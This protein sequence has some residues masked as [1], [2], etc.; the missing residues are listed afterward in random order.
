MSPCTFG[1]LLLNMVFIYFL[2]P[3]LLGSASSSSEGNGGAGSTK[4]FVPCKVCGDKASGYHYGVTSCEG[5]KVRKQNNICVFF[6][7]ISLHLHFFRLVLTLSLQMSGIPASLKR[8][9]SKRRLTTSLFFLR[10]KNNSGS[11]LSQRASSGGVFRNRSSTGACAMASA[12]SSGSTA[13]AASTAASRNASPS[14]CRAIVSITH[15]FCT[16]YST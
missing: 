1:I 11:L 10:K 7:L 15:L 14:A 9:V 8:I 12:W 4:T 13:T 6:F 2:E 3:G 16:L 5:C